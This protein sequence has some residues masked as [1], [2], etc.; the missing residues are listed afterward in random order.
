MQTRFNLKNL[1][2][3]A[4]CVWAIVSFAGCTN[5]NSISK[6]NPAAADPESVI[7]LPAEDTTRATELKPVV[8]IFAAKD[9]VGPGAEILL[10]AEAIDPA[11]GAVSVAWDTTAGIIINTDGSSA[12]FKAPEQTSKAVVSCVATDVRGGRTT[13]TVEIEVIGNSTYRLN[14]T[15]DRTAIVSGK[16]SGDTSSPFVPVG[17]ARV[18]MQGLGEIGIT[19]SDG[20]VE[21][22]IDQTRQV[23]TWSNVIVKYL[24]WEITYT[25]LLSVPDGMR[26]VD[27]LT[28][29][30]GYDRISM[31]VARGDSFQL[32]RGMIEVA[33]V[34]NAAGDMRPVAEVSVGAGAAASVNADLSGRA[35]ISAMS[36][37]NSETSI[38]LARTGYYTLEGYSVPV[39]IDGLTLVRAN[40]ERVGGISALE[41]VM[42]WTR[43]FNGQTVFPV[44]GPFEIGFGQPM[45]KNSV[46]NNIRLNVQNRRTGQLS[47]FTGIELARDFRIEWK[48]DTVMQLYPVVP[49]DA[50]TRYSIIVSEWVARAADGRMLKSYNGLYYEFT[51]DVDPAPKVLS[52][53]PRNGE[54][55]VGRNGPFAIRF[56]RPIKPDSLSDNLEIQITSLDSGASM[57][58]TGTT[59][60][61]YFSV[62]WRDS[63][64]LVELVPYMMLRPD[65]SYLIRF[66]SG[67]LVSESGRK[68]QGFEKLW[69]QFTTGKL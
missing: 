39:A 41:A 66:N 43:P 67:N 27:N 26:I 18:E 40:M 1:L 28:F 42:S 60:K 38:R 56:D 58:V 10:R 12:V 22:N 55:G 25:A 37:G 4:V 19:S 64:T 8:N 5:A 63:N 31:A 65:S 13:A 61:S 35:I 53:S 16:A 48:N 46:F 14:I 11:G 23:A 9:V 59:L 20:M 24:D 47:A 69:G 34:E 50:D 29:Y 57:T 49:L 44:T 45:E 68:V 6:L 3:V 62:T 33:A 17:G 30:P 21:F 15:A 54:T 2:Y 52:T 36:S 32:K 51:T 7:N